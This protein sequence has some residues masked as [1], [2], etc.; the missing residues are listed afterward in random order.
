MVELFLLAFEKLLENPFVLASTILITGLAILTIKYRT[1]H[2]KRNIYVD[3][4]LSAEMRFMM[5]KLL[6]MFPI[7]AF[8]TD[9]LNLASTAVYGEARI[10]FAYLLYY[11]PM[12]LYLTVSNARMMKKK[13]NEPY[14]K[15]AIYILPGISFHVLFL[16]FIMSC[17][18]NAL[19]LSLILL[20]GGTVPAILDC[21]ILAAVSPKDSKW[22]KIEMNNGEHYDVEYKDFLERKGDVHLRIRDKSGRIKEVIIFRSDD[23]LKKKIYSKKPDVMCQN[24]NT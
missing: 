12:L 1:E 19:I 3:A 4:E 2:V 23:V 11:V 21:G 14:W 16:L 20:M 7:C 15:C 22:I 13:R 18:R 17:D 6:F 10:P 24:D 8:M 9:I 5:R